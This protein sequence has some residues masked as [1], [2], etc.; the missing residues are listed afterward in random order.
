MTST[1]LRR[2]V[3]GLG[4]ARG[5]RAGGLALACA[6]LGA[7]SGGGLVVGTPRPPPPPAEA[8]VPSPDGDPNSPTFCGRG[9]SVLDVVPPSG[10]CVKH[11][12]QVGE[13]R[14]LAFAENGDLY[15]ASPSLGT[16]GGAQGGEAAIVVL[17]DDNRD[18]IA[19]QQMFVSGVKD[20][21]GLAI[22]GGFVYYTTASSVWRTPYAAERKRGE[23]VTM[24]VPV[25][26]GLPAK[27][28]GGGRWTHG[29]A[30]SKG[31]Q[32]LA[33]RGEYG[34][35]NTS[36]GGEI[37]AVSPTGVPTTLASGFRN[38]MYMNCHFKDDVCAAMELGDDLH[39]GAREKMVIIH[40]STNYGFPCCYTKR[41]PE[42]TGAMCDDITAEDAFFQLEK[43]P[44][45]FD[46]ER[47]KWPAPFKDGVFV[48]LHGSAYSTPEWQ[49]AAIVY[50]ATS[51]TTHAPVQD[52][53]PFL[54]GFGPEGSVLERP[55]DV[56]FSPDG[57]MFFA[58]DH[59]GRVFWVAPTTL[60]V[61]N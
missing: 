50:A 55:A 43:T 51:P 42:M 5:V 14:A 40:P 16:P 48:A 46:W 53:Q 12:A 8:G 1:F 11:Y 52:W 23:P 18:G 56:K 19:E 58:D 32:L 25:N 3:R 37:S 6:A 59:S 2:T 28:A 41:M 45:G 54:E 24:G 36:P 26:L 21:H 27:F 33:S 34:Q 35:C 4:A 20:V 60:A 9:A 39:A 29:V 61:P 57:R 17:T 15:V 47:G 31:G 13:P 7:C 49:G 38:P 22:G 10:F 30:I 44:F